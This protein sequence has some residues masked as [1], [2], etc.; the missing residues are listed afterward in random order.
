[1]TSNSIR[2]PYPDVPIPDV[3][4]PEFVL[5]DA[6]T[7]ASKPA[8]IDG[9]S[10]RAITFGELAAGARLAAS[11]LAARG[12]APTEVFAIYCPNLHVTPTS[13]SWMNLVEM[14]FSII[15][16]Q[17]IR[18]GSRRCVDGLVME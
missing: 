4:L 7:R 14:F 18:R 3:S 15:T 10:G 8:L 2:S 5:A 12:F 13:A 16:R 17:A 1:M 9:P 11:G 6:A